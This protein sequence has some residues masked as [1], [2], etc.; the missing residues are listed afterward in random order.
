M[1][2]HLQDK[3]KGWVLE[4]PAECL[5]SGSR[6]PWWV[7]RADCQS[8]PE[9]IRA[10]SSAQRAGVEPLQHPCRFGMGM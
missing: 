5:H 9:P 6:S 7:T 1:T 10:A 2:T 4:Q 8:N 3:I